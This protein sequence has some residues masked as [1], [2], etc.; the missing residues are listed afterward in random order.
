MAKNRGW[1]TLEITGNTSEEVSE[2]DLEHIGK[3]IGDGY[4]S[5][6]VVQDEE[7]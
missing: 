2:S 5:G 3:M 6:E 4:T 1:W 7:D